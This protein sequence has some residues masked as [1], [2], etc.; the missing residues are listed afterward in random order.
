MDS[1]TFSERLMEQE[2]V[3][4]VPGVSFGADACVRLSYTCGM[5]A[6]RE[7]MDRFEAFVESV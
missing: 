7:G 4:V 3:A 6:I 2:G 5:E 1:V